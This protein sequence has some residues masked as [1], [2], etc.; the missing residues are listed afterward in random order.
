M[1]H[2]RLSPEEVVRRGK[3]LYESKIRAQVEAGNK[4]KVLVIDV[5][6]GDYE[7]GEDSLPLSERLHAKHK[8][9]ALY[10]MRI[11]YPAFGRIGGPFAMERL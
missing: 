10:A 1:P 3:E 5:E 9:A 8:D 7:I 11:G 4:G 2:T 6:T